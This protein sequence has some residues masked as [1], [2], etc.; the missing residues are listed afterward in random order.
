MII[1][2]CP[3]F[4]DHRNVAI[5]EDLLV[6]DTQE[7]VWGVGWGWGGGGVRLCVVGGGGGYVGVGDGLIL[8][9]SPVDL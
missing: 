7:F 6:K 8:T 3:P 5:I 1:S 4:L 9:Y 2:P